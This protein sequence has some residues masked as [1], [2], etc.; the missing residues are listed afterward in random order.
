MA[1]SNIQN[2]F[3]RIQYINIRDNSSRTF[4]DYDFFYLI[5]GTVRVTQDAKTYLLSKGDIFLFEP[6]NKYFV[7]SGGNN[8]VL[9]IVLNKT[10]IDTYHPVRLGRFIMNSAYDGSRNYEPIRQFLLQISSANS[11]GDRHKELRLSSLAFSLLFYIEEFHFEEELISSDENS[12]N[13]E[14][15]IQAIQNYI[16][17]NYMN[18][19]T[20][21]ELANSLALSVPYLSTFFKQNVGTTFN[22]YLNQ[23]RL[24][25]AVEELVY[26][27]KSITEIT[28]DNGFPSMNAFHKLFKEKFHTTPNKYRIDFQK[29]REFD[30]TDISAVTEAIKIEEI[31]PNQVS[32]STN[33]AHYLNEIL[34]PLKE[35]ITVADMTLTKSIKPIWK[36]M[37]NVGDISAFNYRFIEQ[38]LTLLQKSVGFQYAR[39]ENIA[40]LNDATL[41]S[42]IDICIDVLERR[43]LTPYFSL[44]IP[45]DQ[46]ET[47]GNRLQINSNE[48]LSLLE[49]IIK[50]CANVHGIDYMATWYYEINPHINTMSGAMEAPT[51]FVDRF[52][53]AYTLIKT[54]VPKAM[55]GG[56][57]HNFMY[58]TADIQNILQQIKSRGI[59]P[60]FLSCGGFPIIAD[61]PLH[62]SNIQEYA[63]YSDDKNFHAN[64]CKEYKKLIYDIYKTSIPVHINYM[65][66]IRTNKLYLNDS[67]YQA[68]FIFHNIVSLINEVDILGFYRLSDIDMDQVYNTAYLAGYPGLLNRYGLYKPG[69]HVL[70][71]FANCRTNLVKKGEDFIIL[72]G[73]VDRYMIGLCNHTYISDA[74]RHN[75]NANIPVSEAYNIFERPRT[76][77]IEL[78]LD[79]LTPG[80]Y[81]LIQ[82]Q[83]NKDYGSILNEWERNNY[84]NGFSSDELDYLRGTNQ[85]KRTHLTKEAPEGTLKFQFQLAPHEVMFIALF[86]HM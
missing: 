33:A 68:S 35:T 26:S 1:T 24:E 37:I 25:H 75:L 43:Q 4:M 13:K 45:L 84:W 12:Q 18:A 3:L 41:F 72:K 34:M 67:C 66:P 83:V 5:D 7:S 51:V 48:Y 86:L 8:V 70:S 44:S 55:V 29:Q 30:T 27:D 21:Q 11:N 42:Q 57:S 28:Y 81:D 80:T 82:F 64:K 56:I 14:G 71:I 9:S 31:L 52:I 32:L 15:R 10:F 61:T 16:R 20:L 78:N 23:V 73:T 54:Y 77:N 40:K 65:G 69:A 39:F 38:Q 59:I 53:K 36:S 74:Y 50:Y 6:G 47:S 76:K 19:I 46:L 63:I 22:A 62:A 17:S 79:N 58:D 2:P 49:E 60:D 85:P